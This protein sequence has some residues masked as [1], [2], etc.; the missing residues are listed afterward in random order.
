[1]KQKIKIIGKKILSLLSIPVIIG[2]FV[3]AH[4]ISQKELCKDILIHFENNEHSF[5]TNENI[6]GLLNSKNIHQ[7]KTKLS[8]ID[9][10][11]LERQIE[12]NEWI[13]NAD[14]YIDANHVLNINILQKEPNIRIQPE[15]DFEDPYYLDNNANKIPYSSQYIPNLPIATVYELSYS[16]QDLAIKRDLVKI[17]NFLKADTFWSAAITQIVVNR[18]GQIELTP[19]LGKYTILIGDADRLDYKMNKL[20]EFLQQGLTTIKWDK[21]DEIDLRFDKQIVCRNLRGELFSNDPIEKPSQRMITANLI[22][23]TQPKEIKTNTT[24]VSAT[25]V[26]PKIQK[27]IP[28]NIEQKKEEAPKIKA[29]QQVKKNDE[30]VGKANPIKQE[31]EIEKVKSKEIVIVKPKEIAVKQESKKNIETPKIEKPKETKKEVTEV[32]QSKFFNE[33]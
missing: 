25:P 5:V 30:V 27:V 29:T 18:S 16:S 21:Y 11:Q 24:I 23:N 13:K 14:I 32:K 15:N 8:E 6:I 4:S 22:E 26:T 31:K 2:A 3:F 7:Q 20:F 19:A 12:E 33:N 17:A 10:Q 9:I 28:K 1:M